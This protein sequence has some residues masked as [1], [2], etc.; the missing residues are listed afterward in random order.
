[1]PMILQRLQQ[2]CSSFRVSGPPLTG[3]KKDVLLLID[4]SNSMNLKQF[5]QM[6]HAITNSLISGWEISAEKLQVSVATYSASA[7]DERCGFDV[8]KDDLEKIILNS[9]FQTNTAPSI[10]KG[11]LG[12]IEIMG[13]RQ[14]PMVIILFTASRKTIYSN[15]DG[16]TAAQSYSQQLCIKQNILITVGVGSANSSLLK[17]LSCPSDL[18]FHS[19]NFD[20]SGSFTRQIT[21]SLCL[22]P[23]MRTTI[24]TTKPT[25]T[26]TTPFYPDIECHADI[27]LMIDT[28]NAVG[29][30][31]E[32][33]NEIDFVTNFLA[34]NWHVG[35]T[36]TEVNIVTYSE[37]NSNSIGAYNFIS[38]E[39]FLY[40][41]NE[42][43]NYYY[44]TK[45]SLTFGLKSVSQMLLHKNMTRPGVQSVVILFT[46]SSDYQDISN[47]KTYAD[48]LAQNNVWIIVVAKGNDLKRENLEAIS[49]TTFMAQ[50]YD[51]Q[52][53]DKINNATC[54]K[55]DPSKPLPITS[56]TP[57]TPTTTTTTTKPTTTTELDPCPEC[58][59]SKA[60]IL[61]L[62][63]GAISDDSFK[64]ETDFV[65]NE[66]IINWNRFDRV[67]LGLYGDTFYDVIGYSNMEKVDDFKA[68]VKSLKRR[69][70]S[71]NITL[72]LKTAL[73]EYEPN[74]AFGCQKTLFFSAGSSDSDIKAAIPYADGLEA[75]GEFVLIEMGD[76]VPK[77]LQT[78]AQLNRTIKWPDYSVTA[79]LAKTVNDMLS[80]DCPSIATTT[81]HS[82]TTSVTTP[83][84]PKLCAKD[85]VL[86]IDV[87]NAMTNDQFA[88]IKKFVSEKL[89]AMWPVNV[90]EL[91]VAAYGYASGGVN[92]YATFD[93]H[94]VSDL[95][96][97]INSNAFRTANGPS[98][99]RGINAINDLQHERQVPTVVIILSAS[100]N[101]DDIKASS[102]LEYPF[103][104]NDNGVIT[105]AFGDADA[106]SL[107]QLATSA[108]F[109]LY[110]NSFS[111]DNQLAKTITDL[112]CRQFPATSTTTSAVIT[113][114]EPPHK[115]LSCHPC[116]MIAF[117]GTT[118]ATKAG[119]QKTVNFTLDYLAPEWH[120]TRSGTNAFTG[121]YDTYSGPFNND[122]EFRTQLMA[123]TNSYT[124]PD[125]SIKRSMQL[126]DNILKSSNRCRKISA[127]LYTYS[128]NYDDV[129]ESVELANELY[130][131]DVNLIIVG[132]GD[133]NQTLL[134][135]LSGSVLMP[136]ELDSDCAKNVNG[137]LCKQPMKPS[138]L[139]ATVTPTTTTPTPPATT[140]DCIHE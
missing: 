108:Q 36:T 92:E 107:G 3:C 34:P 48:S 58:V 65:A 19:D 20:F 119:L 11:L 56:T 132:L 75:K 69:G 61:I 9:T 134:Q 62:L 39:E 136:T 18:S 70:N 47:A 120:I 99:R 43:R 129:A 24:T 30:L 137:L 54:K 26:T 96:S 133:A 7:F 128:S 50:N 117:D 63:D 32:F 13:E 71:P 81:V 95:Q 111:G 98:I 12:A 130:F 85:V 138:D 15:E 123:I 73:K 97:A 42:L 125:P 14:N 131:N 113:T 57:T 51:R 93:I 106:A 104:I 37:E 38:N 59:P 89:I 124:E 127:I 83:A 46:Y 79:Q 101:T 82:T 25:T 49:G 68:A 86:L 31:T 72:A 22:T 80:Q 112:I 114:T 4:S 110:S 60:N 8:N 74:P 126:L 64:A 21:S 55:N 116:I 76:S 41:L 94:S 1:M 102:V 87:S 88:Q 45:P 121:L 67:A 105:V 77:K 122:A 27:T 66:M 140:T 2:I 118:A 16:I 52:L 84:Q 5:S 10:R 115:D 29:S 23:P 109:S 90:N 35:P 17:S 40:E 100:S 6:K 28:S 139:P 33:T 91:E 53:A 135:A 78:L 44:D 103:R